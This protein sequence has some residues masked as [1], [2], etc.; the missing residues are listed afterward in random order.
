MVNIAVFAA[1]AFRIGGVLR[2]NAAFKPVCG[3]WQRNIARHGRQKWQDRGKKRQRS[4]K[5]GGKSGKDGRGCGDIH[6]AMPAVAMGCACE[7]LTL[8]EVVQVLA[9][10][11]GAATIELKYHKRGEMSREVPP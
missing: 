6:V 3:L 5:V 11:G 10:P 2:S 1:F 4:G 9:A 8:Y 7:L